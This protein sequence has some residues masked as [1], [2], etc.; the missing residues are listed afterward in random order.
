MYGFRIKLVCLTKIVGLSKASKGTDNRKH[1]SL[2]WNL[3]IFGKLQI[4][5]VL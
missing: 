4:R 2:L 1:A 3:S 5:N